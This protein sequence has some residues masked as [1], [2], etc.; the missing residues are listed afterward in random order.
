MLNPNPM[1]LVQFGSFSVSAA[2]QIQNFIQS[3]GFG[4]SGNVYYCNP[5]SGNDLN[6]G[7]TPA[8]AVQTPAAGYA[9]LTSGN[10]DILVLVGNGATTGSARLSSGF[11]WAKNAAHLIGVAPPSVTY[12]YCRIAPTSGVTA[13]ANFFTVSGNGCVFK[14][15]EFWHGFSTGIA[16]MICLTVTGQ[17][18]C[19]INCHIAGMGDAASAVSSTSRCVLL[20]GT[21]ASDNYFGNC[22]IGVDIVVRTSANATVE[23]AGNAPRTI[24]ENCYFPVYS[25]DGNQYILLVAAASG[26][27]RW[28][29]FKGCMA[30]A[31]VGGTALGNFAS[32][33]AG[34]GGILILDSTTGLYNI[35]A[36]GVAGTKSQTFVSGATSTGGVRGIVAS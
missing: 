16:A 1:G 33:A 2:Q 5:A 32:L 20:S 29:M 13:F 21:G 19:F 25:S 14:N 18:N 4:T 6:N 24:F 27:D 30:T 11:T 12:N 8:S 15:L 31:F 35:T 9:L 36:I 34:C 10:N 3:Q 22:A 26:L 28:V 7:L 17:G 23:I